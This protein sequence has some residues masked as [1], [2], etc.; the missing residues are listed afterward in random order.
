MTRVALCGV[1]NI[2]KVHLSNLRSLRGC[3]VGGIYSPQTHEIAQIAAKIR[4]HAYPSAEA[5]FSDPGVDAIVIASPS[6][7]HRALTEAA[8][9]AGK[10]VFVEKPL[11]DSLEDAQA[12]VAAA[13]RHPDRV[14]QVGFCER[15]NPQYM[16]A[17][18]AVKAGALGTV[19][20]IHS[21]R[22]APYALGD[23]TWPLGVLDTAVHN[24]DLILWLLDEL[25]V[26]VFSRGVQLYPS[27]DMQHSVTTLME[28]SSGALATDTITWLSDE[29]HPLSQCARSRMHVIGDAGSFEIDL[30]SRPSALLNHAGYHAIDTEILG[31]EGYYSCLKLQFEGFLRSVEEG[32]AILA[33]VMDAYRAEQVVLSIQESL[34]RNAPVAIA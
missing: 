34:R 4:V 33:P 24:I 8:L 31:G 27:S 18:S 14:V 28:F 12:I 32:A 29:K 9:A 13:A 26:E 2:G 15:F 30:A 22:I 16:E 25:P 20:C 5:M 19:R 7:T 1:G 23:T 3:E 17:R 10:H 6:H 11:A 21:S